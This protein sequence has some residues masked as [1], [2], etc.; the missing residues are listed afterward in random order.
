M[1]SSKISFLMIMKLVALKAQKQHIRPMT[2]AIVRGTVEKAT[3][4]SMA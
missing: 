3:M 1:G 2:V 4:P